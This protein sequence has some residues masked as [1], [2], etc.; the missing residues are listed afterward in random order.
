MIRVLI[1]FV[2]AVLVLSYA[3]PCAHADQVEV[4]SAQWFRDSR[5][6][7]PLKETFAPSH[8]SPRVQAGQV[9]FK[10]SPRFAVGYSANLPEQALGFCLFSTNP[11]GVGFY[12]DLKTSV[13]MIYGGDDF[14]DNIS[15]HEAEGWGDSLR[16]EQDT[17]ISI[18]GGVTLVLSTRMAVYGGVGYSGNT[19]FR[20]YYDEFHILGTNGHYWVEADDK[21]HV[22]WLGGAV[23][24]LGKSWGLQI[25]GEAQ[26][27][28]V[29]AGVF[30]TR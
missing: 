11:D 28:G 29:T 5:S 1:A 16:D 30:W 19:F 9:D 13:P 25:G 21:S 14:Y 27:A 23:F 7:K 20:E 10:S 22:N 24:I 12:L 17:W 15:V 8:G 18:N 3:P 26:P 4:G 2:L 6:A